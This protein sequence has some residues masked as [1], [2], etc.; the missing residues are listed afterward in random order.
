MQSRRLIIANTLLGLNDFRHREVL[1]MIFESDY[2]SGV[3]EYIF[4]TTN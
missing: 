1:E 4:L 2:Y 3:I